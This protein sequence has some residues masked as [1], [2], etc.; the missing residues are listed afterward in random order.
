MIGRR[1][2]CREVPRWARVC[3]GSQLRKVGQKAAYLCVVTPS[4]IAEKS[5]LAPAFLSR[6]I[7]EYE[8]LTQEMED[9]RKELDSNLGA[10]F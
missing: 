5:F 7:E 2:Q 4:G 8:V 3:E 9:L 6:K 1:E 10:E